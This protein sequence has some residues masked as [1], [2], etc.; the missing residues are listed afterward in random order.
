[1]STPSGKGRIRSFN[2]VTWW[3]EVELSPSSAPL[4]FHGTSFLASTSRRLPEVGEEVLVV[5]A[6][7]ARDKVVVIRAGA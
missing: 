4:R 5:F 2:P 6:D 7:E 1:M 3:G